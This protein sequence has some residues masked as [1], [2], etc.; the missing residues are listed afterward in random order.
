MS[1]PAVAIDVLT[2][3]IITAWKVYQPVEVRGLELGQACCEYRDANK[4]KG[5]YGSK[6]QGLLQK[7]EELSIPTSTAYYWMNRYQVSVGLKEEIL[8]Q[9]NPELRG[10]DFARILINNG[11]ETALKALVVESLRGATEKQASELKQ[12][13]KA[14][15]DEQT[16]GSN[17]LNRPKEDWAFLDK[18][19]NK[20]ESKPITIEYYTK[21]E[22]A[23]Q[24]ARS[25]KENELE[26]LFGGCGFHYY[27]KQNCA[28]K[29]PHF[30]T[31][32]SALTEEQTKRLA[33]ILTAGLKALKD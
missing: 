20:G 1:S 11:N 7:L 15:L 14:I 18:I 24:E 22:L 29:V 5:G 21:N 13:T 23:N 28:T 33:T 6:G 27:I 12:A 25:S 10:K 19:S 31:T 30:N 4:S 26:Q 17:R 2:Q 32:F 16:L 9:P 8:E 3:N